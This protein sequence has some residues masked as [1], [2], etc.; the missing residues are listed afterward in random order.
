MKKD[1]QRTNMQKEKTMTEYAMCKQL[2]PQFGELK[3]ARYNNR[4]FI[5][6]YLSEKEKENGIRM[7]F[8]DLVHTWLAAFERLLAGRQQ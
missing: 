8:Y 5:Y 2:T 3:R 4:I 6:L 7:V 1:G